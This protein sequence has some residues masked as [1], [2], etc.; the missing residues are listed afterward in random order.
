[1]LNFVS[2][3]RAVES[4]PVPAVSGWRQDGGGPV[5][6][7]DSWQAYLVEVAHYLREVVGTDPDAL[8]VLTTAPPSA[9]WLR[10][11]VGDAVLVEDFL[12]SMKR[13]RFSD[14]D[15]AAIFLAFFTR[16]LGLLCIQAAGAVPA[17]RG[18]VVE[19]DAYSTLHRLRPLL[20]RDRD[21]E[22]F[23]DAV[24]DILTGLERDLKR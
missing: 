2:Q 6:R 1:M 13:Y 21:V 12:G 15:A 4:V 3:P 22:D 18:P 7:V 11:P 8:G 20:S 19:V 5:S 17:P 10:P 9:W 16:L 14:E 23:E 24:D